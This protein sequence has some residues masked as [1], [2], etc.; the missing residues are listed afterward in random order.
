MALSDAQYVAFLVKAARRLNRTLR[1]EDTVN[2]IVVN[3]STGE[4]T[5]PLNNDALE[6]LLVLQAECLI[7]QRDT[8]TSASGQS[9]DG[10]YVKDGEQTIDTS[11]LA[12]LRAKYIDSDINPCK[13]LKAG[14]IQY[15][16]D[17]M[18]GRCIW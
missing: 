8:N 17:N 14:I 10:V 16:L 11:S 12:N 18:N 15:K 7:L 13:E 3:E 2:E 9:G 4:I 1:L 5:S 6:D